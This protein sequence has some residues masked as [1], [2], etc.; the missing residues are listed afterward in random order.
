MIVGAY[1]LVLYCDTEGCPMASCTPNGAN[2]PTPPFRT[3]A[4]SGN[5]C[6]M[7]ARR[8]GW[9][10]FRHTGRCLCPECTQK[11]RRAFAA[12]QTP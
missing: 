6:R 9:T 7:R 8:L 11:K 2:E 10:L 3:Q 5:E 4:E 1:E 12:A